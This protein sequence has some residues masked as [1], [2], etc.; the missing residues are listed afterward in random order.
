RCG[1]SFGRKRRGWRARRGN[2]GH[3][4]AD[5]VGHKRRQA[6]VLATEQVVLH[7]DVLTFDVAGFVETLTERGHVALRGLGRSGIDEAHDRHRRLLCAR[8]ERPRSRRAAEQRDE[9]A[10]AA[11][12]ITSSAVAR[13]DGGTVSPS[14]LAV[15]M[16]MTS[17]NLLD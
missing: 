6:I 16:L 3:A 12:S 15:C 1:R 11:H 17:S 5:E 14:I 13:S 7:C 9:L 2:N 10:T 8:R 4:A